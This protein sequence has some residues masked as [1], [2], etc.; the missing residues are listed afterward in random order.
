[1]SIGDAASALRQ[2][3]FVDEQ[4]LKFKGYAEAEKFLSGVEQEYGPKASVAFQRIVRAASVAGVWLDPRAM[5]AL[6]ELKTAWITAQQEGPSAVAFA[7]KCIVAAKGAMDA[8]T[9]AARVDLQ[10][11]RTK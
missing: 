7:A 2:L 8:L 6:E 4:R 11:L 1:E 9:E 10:L 5:A 3:V